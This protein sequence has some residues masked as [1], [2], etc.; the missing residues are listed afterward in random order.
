MIELV[1]KEVLERAPAE[2]SLTGIEIEG[3]QIVLLTKNPEFMLSGQ[4]Y[5]SE[6]AKVLRK[7]VVIRTAPQYLLD[8]EAASA[9]ISSILP[10]EAGLQRIIFNYNTGEAISIADN[11]ALLEADINNLTQKVAKETGWRLVVEKKFLSDSKTFSQVLHVL[12]S[13]S[14][15]K[16]SFL[17]ETGD[18]IFRTPLS[19]TSNCT[20]SFLG[21]VEQVGR[22]AV[23]VSTDES[24]VLVDAGVNPGTSQRGSMFP[25]LDYE[26][27]DFESLDAVV[28]SHAH[29]DHIGALPL[30]TKY[31]YQGPFYM[32]EPTLYLLTILLEDFYNVE[33]RSGSL[34]FFS[35]KDVKSVIE[36][37]IVVKYNQVTDVSPDIKITPYNAGHILGS[38]LVDLSIGDAGYS[39]L[40]TSDFKLGRSLLLNPA[41]SRF[42]RVDTLIMEST[43]GGEGDVMPSRTEVESRLI[44]LVN[45]TFQR[46][47]RVLIPTSAVGRAQEVLL[48]LDRA[49]ANKSIEEAPVFVDGMITEVSKVH[50]AFPSYLSSELYSLITEEVVNPLESEYFVPVKSSSERPEAL[51]AGKAVILS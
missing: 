44:S 31:G 23:L 30:L 6:L 26:F 17:R 51:S 33:T 22:S 1:R 2:A 20:L 16:S 8:E 12:T 45:E 28:V 38:S 49:M 14:E 21:G 10:K 42:L 48:I 47:G 9:T 4:Q 15:S 43:Y 7:R 50:S 41:V 29:L 24:R 46:G 39:V 34:S 19:P 32:T 37:T 3:P 18:R 11:I 25:R 5:A 40:Y 35:L 36:Q 13:K 27:D